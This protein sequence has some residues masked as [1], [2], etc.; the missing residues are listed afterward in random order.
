MNEIVLTRFNETLLFDC[1]DSHE[2]TPGLSLG[3]HKY[4]GGTLNAWPVSKTHYVILCDICGRITK[5]V[6][7]QVDTYEKLC[8][9]C[10]V[11]KKCPGF[12]YDALLA[13]FFKKEPEGKHPINDP[14]M[15]DHCCAAD[16]IGLPAPEPGDLDWSK[17]EDLLMGGPDDYPKNP[18]ANLPDGLVDE[19]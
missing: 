13:E 17:P 4:C 10:N 16:H 2:I 9:W 19:Q 18:P 7:N 5:P 6:P 12:H 15:G 3:T 8:M 14:E 11:V 1:Q